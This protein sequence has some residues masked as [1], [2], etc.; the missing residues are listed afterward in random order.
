MESGKVASV[1]VGGGDD[2][3]YFTV[4]PAFEAGGQLKCLI[5]FIFL[6]RRISGLLR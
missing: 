2:L 4:R 1:S 3:A 6:I 5:R